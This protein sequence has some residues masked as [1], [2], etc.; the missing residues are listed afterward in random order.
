M[1]SSEATALGEPRVECRSGRKTWQDPGHILATSSLE[2]HKIP[3]NVRLFPGG[4]CTTI[5]PQLR[6]ILGATRLDPGLGH[7]GRA[8]DL[9]SSTRFAVEKRGWIAECSVGSGE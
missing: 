7:P 6:H 9:A 5:C 3:A 1:S 8:E 4:I 2:P